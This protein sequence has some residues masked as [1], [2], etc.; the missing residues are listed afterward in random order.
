M[1]PALARGFGMML[2]VPFGLVPSTILIVLCVA[3]ARRELENRAAM[4]PAASRFLTA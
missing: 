2:H 1:A 4:A 3:H